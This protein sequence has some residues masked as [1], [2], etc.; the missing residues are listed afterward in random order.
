MAPNGTS[1]A[2]GAAI[3]RVRNPV[4]PGTIPRAGDGNRTRVLSLGKAGRRQKC[5]QVE[6]CKALLPGDY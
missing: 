4:L 1:A 6:H 5:H 2:P 3:V